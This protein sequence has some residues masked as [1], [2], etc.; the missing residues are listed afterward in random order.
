MGTHE[1]QEFAEIVRS[2]I[3][4]HP[5][6]TSALGKAHIQLAAAKIL[7]KKSGRNW[8]V[9]ANARLAAV[10]L[11]LFVHEGLQRSESGTGNEPQILGIGMSELYDMSRDVITTAKISR[12]ELLD[13]M[14]DI[15]TLGAATDLIQTNQLA[16]ALFPS[17][18]VLA[19]KGP[20]LRSLWAGRAHAKD[21]VDVVWLIVVTFGLV[22]A[23]WTSSL[24]WEDPIMSRTTLVSICTWTGFF[25]VAVVFPAE[26]MP[27]AGLRLFT[28]LILTHGL[29]TPT[30]VWH[31]YFHGAAHANDACRAVHALLCI[32]V[33][34]NGLQSIT[35]ACLLQRCTTYGWG[36]IRATLAADG[37]A[38]VVATLLMRCL[39]PPAAYPPGLVRFGGALARGLM[40]IAIAL[41]G[42]PSV[43]LLARELVLFAA[44]WL[45]SPSAS[46]RLETLFISIALVLDGSSNEVHATEVHATPQPPKLGSC[47]PPAADV[48]PAASDAA[49][50]ACTAPPADAAD[51]KL[52]VLEVRRLPHV[53]SAG[54]SAD[55]PWH[56]QSPLRQK[57]YQNFTRQRAIMS[58]LALSGLLLHSLFGEWDFLFTFGT[59][60]RDSR[61][62]VY[63][64]SVYSTSL[65]MAA[66]FPRD[67]S[68]EAG[69]QFTVAP[70]IAGSILRC[71]G[72]ALDLYHTGPLVNDACTC[73]HRAT[74]VVLFAVWL[75]A[76][77]QGLAARFTW[78]SARCV[79]L[80]EGTSLVLCTMLIRALGPSPSYPPGGMSFGAALARGGFAVFLGAG[81][82][83]PQNR[84]RIAQHANSL[85]LN[86][87]IISLAETAGGVLA[88][89]K[90]E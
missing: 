57:L 27:R 61:V 79:H 80:L 59:L 45:G 64:V 26:T 25:T 84:A 81:V 49:P 18:R 77:L 67:P 58:A 90:S 69:A 13:A 37:I 10:L 24:K 50:G 2:W 5:V 83:S 23:F 16:A 22:I 87:L 86:Q 19:R 20:S 9:T 53:E 70:V 38:F 4:A 33:A 73:V 68:S 39:G 76:A 17:T 3:E 46:S 30:V 82:L 54:L 1:A 52:D 12:F 63:V 78:R 34:V 47:S 62:L 51:A 55:L 42:T 40:T 8:L 60:P 41:V 11:V 35:R 72:V 14:V 21:F 66:T 44:A 36:S 88:S 15:D 56:L 43:R 31:N 74:S 65:I 6:S 48:L 32:V 75:I 89:T 7:A 28:P 71:F 85:G 29:I